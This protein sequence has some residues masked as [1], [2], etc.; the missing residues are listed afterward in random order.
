MFRDQDVRR[1][2]VSVDDTLWVRVLNALADGNKRSSRLID[3]QLVLVA[4]LIR[5]VPSTNSITKYGEFPSVEPA[6]MI[7]A[8]LGWSIIVIA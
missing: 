3:F 1:L 5:A 4:V 7:F 8:M 2:Q 6:S